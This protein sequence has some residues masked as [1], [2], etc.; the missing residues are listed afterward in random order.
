MIP[1]RAGAPGIVVAAF[2]LALAPGCAGKK[3]SDATS[4]FLAAPELVAL[5]E[6]EL[7]DRDFRKART[8]LERV[9][10]SP[11]DR[12]ELEPKVRLLLADVAFWQGDD[13]SM[14]EARAK[15]QDF[16]SLYPNHPRAAYAQF[17]AG[18]ASFKQVRDPSR[19]QAQ[20]KI[21]IADLREVLKRFPDSPYAR[22]ARSRLDEAEGLLAEHEYDVALFY[23]KK[24]KYKAAEDRL[25]GLLDAYPRYEARDK[26]YVGLG[27][28][29]LGGGNAAE[30]KAFLDKVIEDW[31]GGKWAAEARETLD[32]FAKRAEKPA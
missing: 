10:Y 11:S 29:L 9:T 19:D 28:A 1:S 17:Q 5:A 21:A 30:G 25:R 7:A 16:A 31:P 26:V 8:H 15:Y 6:A 32:D 22:A 12:T 3:K 2:A 18:I 13:L 24:K 4:Q 20:T 27:R 14:I 23:L